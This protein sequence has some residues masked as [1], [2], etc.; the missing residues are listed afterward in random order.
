MPVVKHARIVTARAF[1]AFKAVLRQRWP[2]RSID[3]R[4]IVIP[5]YKPILT[6]CEKFRPRYCLDV[7][8]GHGYIS[9][10]LQKRGVM[11]I[12][13]D[14]DI[15]TLQANIRSLFINA[16]AQCLPFESNVLDMILAFELLEH[17]PSPEKA[18]AEFHRVLRLGGILILTTPTPRALSTK[19]PEHISVK[20]RSYWMSRL[21]LLGFNI[22]IIPYVYEVKETNLPHILHLYRYYVSITSTKLLCIKRS[23]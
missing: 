18:L 16:D 13:L 3:R 20:P 21:R 17:L 10:Y 19:I 2:D 11:C 7:G 23:N 6:M 8:C 12:G 14:V 4:S 9:E 1:E 5:W 15:K 22:K